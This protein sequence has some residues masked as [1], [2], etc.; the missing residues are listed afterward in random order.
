MKEKRVNYLA[1]MSEQQKDDLR[2]KEKQTMKAKRAADQMTKN[3]EPVEMYKSKAVLSKAA[4]KAFR[5]LPTDPARAY[6]MNQSFAKR[7]KK[8]L[9]PREVVDDKQTK[10][11]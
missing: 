6:E 3:I 11:R 9:G 1:R 2:K 7:M 10:G 5:A 8:A 4:V